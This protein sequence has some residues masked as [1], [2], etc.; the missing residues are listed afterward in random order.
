MAQSADAAQSSAEAGGA[1]ASSQ[2]GA[3]AGDGGKSPAQVTATAERRTLDDRLILNGTL[4]RGEPTALPDVTGTVT[5][6]PS[7]GDVIDKG[8]RVVEIEGTP[9]VLF[10]GERPFWRDLSVD[11][12]RGEDI[13]QLEQN[14]ADLGWFEGE[15]DDVYDWRTRDAVRRWQKEHRLEGDG[16]FSQSSVVVLRGSPVR[17]D[18][19][20]GKLGDQ[21]GSVATYTGTTMEIGASMSD[22]QVK[23]VAAGM[24]AEVEFPDGTK[25]PGHVSEVIPA[26][27]KT[28]TA[29]AVK[30]RAKVVLDDP[31]VLDGR[32]PASVKV[33]IVRQGESEPVLAVPAVALLATGDGAYAVEVVRADGTV[34]RVP[35]EVGRMSDAFVAIKEPSG[36][37]EG[38]KVVIGR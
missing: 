19:V 27:A 11:S 18:R 8:Q 29:E 31:A 12:P 34:E 14:L 20:T 17:I 1:A 9:R 10:T 36:L 35:V 26:Q 16:V 38:D 4:S 28:A 37:A 6:L 30:A 21:G 2:S 13:R 3:S 7:A 24:P 22:T 25:A 23:R 5:A 32:D 15:V 33:R